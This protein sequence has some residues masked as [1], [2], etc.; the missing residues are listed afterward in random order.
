[1]P[2]FSVRLSSSRDSVRVVELAA[3]YY[4]SPPLKLPLDMLECELRLISVGKNHPNDSKERSFPTASRTK[5]FWELWLDC[6]S[7]EW[8]AVIGWN[9]PSQVGANCLVTLMLNGPK[10]MELRD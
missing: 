4:K 3:Q 6:K 10:L 9:V 2:D 8:P 1:M 7:G 5:P